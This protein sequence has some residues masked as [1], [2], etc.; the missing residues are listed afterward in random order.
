[1]LRRAFVAAS[2]TKSR[3]VKT[4]RPCTTDGGDR[5]GGGKVGRPACGSAGPRGRSGVRARSAPGISESRLTTPPTLLGY[6]DTLLPFRWSGEGHYI[7]PAPIANRH[8]KRTWHRSVSDGYQRLI[9]EAGPVGFR[10]LSGPVGQPCFRDIPRP[11]GR[12][13]GWTRPGSMAPPPFFDTAPM[14]GRRAG[15]RFRLGPSTLLP[16]RA[17]PRLTYVLST[18]VGRL[19]LDEI[20]H[21][22]NAIPENVQVSG[23]AQSLSSI[24]YT[25]KGCT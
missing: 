12:G 23:R 3:D 6:S 18:K 17:R 13:D 10:Y 5:L 24:D 22:R 11:R 4:V 16:P 2:C 25:E 14:Y 21:R 19:V 9:N 15:G 8:A 1:V 20:D 7:G